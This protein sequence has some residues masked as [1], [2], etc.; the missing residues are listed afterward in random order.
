MRSMFTRESSFGNLGQFI[1]SLG[2]SAFALAWSTSAHAHLVLI[3][4]PSWVI[5]DSLGNPQKDAPCGGESGL[6]T[7]II[8]TYRAGSTIEVRWQET[9]GHPGHFRISLATDRADLVDPVVETT[10]GDGVTGVSISAVITDPP[11]YPVLLDGLFP[12]A[13]AFEAQEEPYSVQL[14]LPQVTCERCTLQV[15]QFMA[16]HVPGYFYHHCADLRIV[17]ADADLPDAAL[18]P[19]SPPVPE[20][21][22]RPTQVTPR[23]KATSSAEDEGCVLGVSRASSPL[24]EGAL[25]LLLGLVTAFRRSRRD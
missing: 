11:S 5:E 3:T 22:V 8:S 18:G 17:P 25:L 19:N 4:P 1:S 7:R 21:G 6:Q 2:L 20:A 16:S 15:V 24:G 14:Q 13:V 9:V 12:R 23:V 10:N